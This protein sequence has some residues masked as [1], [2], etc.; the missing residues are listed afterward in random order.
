MRQDIAVVKK[1]ER[2]AELDRCYQAGNCPAARILARRI[3]EDETAS[4]V[5]REAAARVGRAMGT[6]PLAALAIGVTALAQIYIFLVH[7]LG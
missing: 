4:P 5:E 1:T 7:L 2:I 3:L 6:D